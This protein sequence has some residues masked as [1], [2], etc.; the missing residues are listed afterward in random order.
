MGKN[1]DDLNVGLKAEKTVK[2]ILEKLFGELTKTENQYDNFDFTNY[3][4]YVEHK[5]RFINF[6]QYDSLYL[7]KPKLTST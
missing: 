6:G 3:K 4:Y 2:P 1:K 5:E 7:E